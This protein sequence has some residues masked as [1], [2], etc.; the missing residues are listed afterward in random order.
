M[1]KKSKK[2]QLRLPA[3]LLAPVGKL[4]RVQLK[5][6]KKRRRAIEK[7]DPFS[8]VDRISDN[9]SPDTDAEEQFGHA[10]ATAI[11]EELDRKIVQ[12]RKALARIKIGSYGLCEK[13]GSL[14]DT[15]RLMVYPEADLC[16]KCEKKRNKKKK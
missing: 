16:M 12:T 6:L 11:R 4:L 9:A 3:N 5:N 7:D 1:A 15:D 8:D 13:C 2:N 10:R 14:I